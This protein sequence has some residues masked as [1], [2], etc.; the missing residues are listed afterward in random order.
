MYVS[1]T[2]TITNERQCH[3]YIYI[4]YNVIFGSPKNYSRI[5]PINPIYKGK[6]G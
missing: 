5:D 3:G 1:G 6:V 2:V 4:N